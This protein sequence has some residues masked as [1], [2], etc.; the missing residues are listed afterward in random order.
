ME[1]A[2]TLAKSEAKKHG[3]VFTL[4]EIIHNKATV[5]S[6][7]D[8]GVIPIGSISEVKR[9]DNVIIRSHGASLSEIKA[10][11][12]LG[13]NIT[14]ATCQAVKNI[15]N[16]V[17]VFSNNGYFIILFGKSTHPEV[18]G[19][20]SRAKNCKVFDSEDLKILDNLDFHMESGKVDGAEIAQRE[21]ADLTESKKEDLCEI[22]FPKNFTKFVILAQTTFNL[23]KFKKYTEKLLKLA[24]TMR[25]TVE[26]LNTICYTTVHNQANAEKVSSM[27]DSVFVIG[28]KESANTNELF[29]ISCKFCKDVRLIQSE[30]G[31]LPFGNIKNIAKL[32]IITGASVQQEPIM[33]VINTMSEEFKADVIVTDSVQNE[34]K[35]TEVAVETVA[36]AEPQAE[37]KASN[38][39]VAQAPAKPATAKPAT[40][41]PASKPSESMD[42]GSAMKKW[43]AQQFQI[44]EG[45]RLKATVTS[46]DTAGISVSID[47]GKNDS[48]FIDKTEVE[49][50]GLYSPENY[51][52]GMQLD[53]VVIPKTD[54]KL[55]GFNL[56][57]KA[58]DAIKIEDEAVKKILEG[59]EFQLVCPQVINGGLL[60]KLGTYAIFVPASQIRIGFVKNVEEY[61]TKKLRL[62]MMPPKAEAPLA[63]GEEPRRKPNPKRIVASQ[64]IILEEERAVKEEAFWEVMQVHNILNGKVKR[65]TAFGAFVSIMGCDCLA[66]ISD[67]SWSKIKDPSEVLE[68]NKSYDFVVLKIDKETCKVS[69]GYK[70]LQKQPYELA[71]EKY[72]VG[73][74]I[75]G[76]VQRIKDFG[77]FVELEPGI[78]GLVHVSEITHKWISNANEV[79]KVGDIVSAKIMNF[80]NN[81]ITL[82]M[83]TLEEPPAVAEVQEEAEDAGNKRGGKKEKGKKSDKEGSDEPRELISGK[84]GATM[85][86]LFKDVDF[87]KFDGGGEE[88]KPKKTT[89]KAEAKAEEGSKE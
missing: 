21:I 85:A 59:E 46:A 79:I 16:Q 29:E 24:I 65:F 20:V 86:D 12:D 3:T 31:L 78:D 70:Q 40:A 71:Q 47:V 39:K 5:N 33:E 66:H 26:I 10:L 37:V 11:E 53:V 67:L 83:K 80:D 60:G 1:R 18:I 52:K 63:E 17:K 48:G 36:T 14:D 51:V 35:A 30:H 42:M 82:S 84:S 2:I 45:N 58:F 19:T 73:D 76:K 43:G 4:G 8:L 62:R 7:K 28:D 34:V 57:K 64:R 13:A 75:T 6:L 72:N 54:P 69:L 22:F 61:A 56:S 55:K 87:A 50:D 89:K 41:K 27:A 25:K 9:G 49:L 77:A 44:R 32:G 81:K 23:A 68:L 15:H 88:K 74:I 38:E